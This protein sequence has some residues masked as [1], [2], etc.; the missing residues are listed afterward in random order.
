MVQCF[1]EKRIIALFGFIAAGVL[2]LVAFL[3]GYLF[4][5]P[6]SSI[7]GVRALNTRQNYRTYG[8]EIQGIRDLLAHRNIII[9]SSYLPVDIR[10]RKLLQDEEA[11]ITVW[12]DSTGLSFNSITL[13]HIEWSQ[14]IVERENVN[15][16]GDIYYTSELFYKIKVN[17]PTGIVNRD[18]SITINLPATEDNPGAAGYNFILDTG[19]SHVVFSSDDDQIVHE[20]PLRVDTL[21]IRNARG[22]INL[23]AP[24]APEASASFYVDIGEVIVD[25]KS[26]TLNCLSPVR[27]NVSIK[28]PAGN[29]VFGNIGGDVSV[30]GAMVDFAQQGEGGIG[31][32]VRIGGTF[33]DFKQNGTAGVGGD[34]EFKAPQGL[35]RV[36]ECRNLTMVD[37]VNASLE[38]T[39][40]V[41]NVNYK[42]TSSGDVAIAQIGDA[43]SL[44]AGNEDRARVETVW[45]NVALYKVWVDT[46]VKSDYGHIRVDF[47][48]IS[49]EEFFGS[50]FEPN[51]KIEGYDGSIIANNI[52]GE[53][54]IFVTALGTATVNAHFRQILGVSR[55]EYGS[56][57][58]HNRNIGNID[59]TVDGGIPY[60]ILKTVRSASARNRTEP[61]IVTTTQ[62]ELVEFNASFVNTGEYYINYANRQEGQEST[63]YL[64][65][66]TSNTFN[67]F[68]R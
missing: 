27:N 30:T 41:R 44:V 2:L 54:D 62:H 63:G 19:L 28:C 45:G 64:N 68:A 47:D 51:L 3:V 34:V 40:K 66:S 36:V 18:S 24:P 33:V 23:P 39:R 13:T 10:V 59:V 22:V 31:G 61:S 1:V 52:C 12:D 25:T 53:T 21:E 16:E 55:I 60:C 9:E 4:V 42:S 38:V 49:Q 48:D 15:T 50:G 43:T 8:T 20:N 56:Q 67:F 37:V 35:L 29:F 58:H 7:F 46:Y 26:V 65:I 5:I 14:V 6:N 57:T 32:N 11:S 17:E